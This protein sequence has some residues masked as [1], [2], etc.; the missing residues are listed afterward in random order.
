MSG[1]FAGD[2]EARYNTICPLIGAMRQ[3][4]VLKEAVRRKLLDC[5]ASFDFESY[6]L[7][8]NMQTVHLRGLNTDPV[9]R[10][11]LG[12]VLRLGISAGQHQGHK[13]AKIHQESPTQHLSM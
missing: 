11:G 5:L 3:T 6:R 10:T 1:A 4:E 2:D 13:R 9:T 7:H 8:L 12:L